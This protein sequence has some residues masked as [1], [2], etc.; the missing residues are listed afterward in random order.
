MTDPAFSWARGRQPGFN[1]ASVEVLRAEASFRAFYR[2]R[3][4]SGDSLVLMV[5]PPDK[6]QNQQFER[7]A[8]VFGRAGIPVPT[9][10]AAERE[11][12][13]YLMTDLGSHELADVY[14]TAQEDS[15]LEA[16]LE[17]LIRLQGVED[18][19]IPPYT[20]SRFADELEIFRDWF[21]GAFIATS[22]PDNC[23]PAFRH[24]VERMPGQLQCCVHRDYHCRNLLFDPDSERLGVVDFQD[25]LMGP[26]SYDLASLLHDC[27]HDFSADEVARWQRFYLER[28]PLPHDPERFAEDMTL[29][30]IQRQLKAVGIF[31]RL[32]LR[33]GKAT[34]L[35]HIQP[36]LEHISQLS[37][38]IAAL[39][40]L[41]DWLAQ[42][43]HPMIGAR[44]DELRAEGGG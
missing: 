35:E 18:P 21:A 8:G 38:P 6:E 12:G 34:H 4:A 36:V 3:A 15:A 33:D 42:L 40:P 16:A 29:T 23:A 41:A 19:A 24:L 2:L 20:Q 26:A 43:D 14:G 1:A 39:A 9:V 22:L 25:A 32:K 13:W 30:A 7:L 11:Q 10:L 17:T 28:S 37:Q 44:I 31:A 5:S 27:Y